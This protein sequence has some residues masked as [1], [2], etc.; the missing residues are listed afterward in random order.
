MTTPTDR[1]RAALEYALGHLDSYNDPTPIDQA[2]RELDG[3]VLVPVEPPH[4]KESQD[5]IWIAS[6]LQNANLQYRAMIAP[7]V[8]GEK[9]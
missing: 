4:D 2:L 1:V 6:Q 7:Y 9:E 8:E 5:R 3:M